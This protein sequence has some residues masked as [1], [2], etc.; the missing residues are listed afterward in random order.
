MPKGHG[1]NKSIHVYLMTA[2]YEKW[3]NL[4]SFLGETQVHFP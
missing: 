1:S 3:F 2:E 4:F